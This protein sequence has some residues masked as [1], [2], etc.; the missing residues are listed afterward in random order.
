MT[1]TR[2]TIRHE[3]CF[4]EALSAVMVGA[5]NGI[6]GHCMGTWSHRHPPGASTNQV[7]ATGPPPPHFN[8]IKTWVVKLCGLR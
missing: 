1:F 7:F 4:T 6:P 3:S 8:L 2:L 5:M